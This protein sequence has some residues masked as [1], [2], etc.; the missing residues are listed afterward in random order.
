MSNPPPG[1]FPSD[2]D[3]S[4][5]LALLNGIVPSMP[6]P[7]PSWGDYVRAQYGADPSLFAMPASD[8]PGF[9]KSP[10]VLDALAA[11]DPRP[12]GFYRS[13]ALL[14]ASTTAQGFDPSLVPT[15]GPQEML[16]GGPGLPTNPNAPLPM[17]GPTATSPTVTPN[18]PSLANSI[19]AMDPG[20]PSLARS[21]IAMG[22]APPTADLDPSLQPTLGPQEILFGGPGLPSSSNGPAVSPGL[23]PTGFS[24]PSPP[25][26][27]LQA[28]FS[29][30]DPSLIRA[31]ATSTPMTGPGA[32]SRPI[33]APSAAPADPND[34]FAKAGRQQPHM[35]VP[36]VPRAE[37]QSAIEKSPY[38]QMVGELDDAANSVTNLVPYLIGVIEDAPLYGSSDIRPHHFAITIPFGKDVSPEAVFEAIRSF[39]APGAPYARDGMN[40]VT[41]AGNNPIWQVVD[42]NTL[43]IK[44]ITRPGH[45]YYPGTVTLSVVKDPD[46]NVSLHIEGKGTGPYATENERVGP[47][48]F[49]L[50]GSSARALY[51]A[52][53]SQSQQPPLGIPVGQSGFAMPMLSS[54]GSA[55]W[56]TPSAKNP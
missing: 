17:T 29:A 54:P 25:A 20:P 40:L 8:T 26:T 28:I 4:S 52:A 34:I 51:G 50:L 22:Y 36:A 21:L 33:D 53:Q 3:V 37:P 45:R 46:G 10:A 2:L 12:P 7:S 15:I 41:L 56:Y 44:N 55:G 49:H 19:A 9:H 14:A 47:L 18:R 24:P 27:G 16:F 30:G 42:P 1:T 48:V 43:T 13:P 38:E 5:L 39:S 32:M 35:S 11:A 23:I 6:S 31:Q